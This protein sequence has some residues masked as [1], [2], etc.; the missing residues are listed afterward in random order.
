MNTSPPAFIEKLFPSIRSATDPED[1]RRTTILGWILLTSVIIAPLNAINHLVRGEFKIAGASVA[2]TFLNL[3]VFFALRKGVSSLRLAWILCTCITVIIWGGVFRR[4]SFDGLVPQSLQLIPLISVFILGPRRGWIFGFLSGL[5]LIGLYLKWS[6]PGGATILSSALILMSFIT[7]AV[8]VS[9]TQ[10][11]RARQALE[12]ARREAEENRR[13]AEL[14]QKEAEHAKALAEKSSA[15]K[16]EFLANMSHEIRTPMNAVIGMTG[17]LL[18]TKLDAEQRSFTEIVR[19]SSEALLA[20][21]NDILDFSKIEAGELQIE[22]LPMSIRECVENAVELL[23]AKAAEKHIELAFHIE[24]DVPVAIEGDPT[25]IQ[26][27]LVNLISNAVKFTEQGEVVITVRTVSPRDKQVTISFEVRDTGRG[28]KPEAIPALF[29]PFTQED[30]STTRRYGGTG[31]GLTICKRLVEAMG[32]K[33]EVQSEVGVGTTMRFSLVG[34]IAPYTRPRYMDEVGPLTEKRILVVDD[35]ATN[36]EIVRRYLDS[37]GMNAITVD[38][39]P[40]ALTALREGGRNLDCAI[41]DM[42]MPEMDGLM[43]A[44]AIHKEPGFQNLPLIMLTSLG[45]REQSEEMRH[46]R[47]FLT[48]PLKPSRLFNTLLA[49]FSPEEDSSQTLSRITLVNEIPSGLRVLLADDNIINQKVALMSLQ[50]LGIR[51]DAVA[52]GLEVI[53]AIRNH[54][55]DLILM[56]VQMP[57]LDGLAATRQIRKMNVRQQPYIIAATANATIEDREE[58][59]AA[60]MNAYMSKPYRLRDLHRCMLDYLQ[61]KP[62]SNPGTVPPAPKSS[63]ARIF[64]SSALEQ[65]NVMFNDD[66]AEIDSFFDGSLPDLARQMNDVAEARNVD[67]H[68]LRSAAHSLKG[69]SGALASHELQQCAATLESRARDGE[70]GEAVKSDWEKVQV[71]HDRFVKAVNDRSYR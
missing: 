41:L 55:Y 47:A 14:A 36:R 31:L 19:T 20:I 62:T 34:T 23:A 2:G 43:L 37:W 51:A 8:V 63:H 56:D 61:T 60:G 44:S 40:A 59:L 42:H 45:Q 54:P 39:G 50:K 29:D 57:E 67:A 69:G 11:V 33:F 64:S 18:E 12:K 52:N 16:T 22:R 35:N 9:E 53:E 30:A 15:A 38:S 6:P 21:I 27:V 4:E 25:R 48:K 24:H 66:Q 65:L 1:R 68:G 32:G 13:L 5:F 17:L 3:A 28:I 26:Q 10:R 7:A 70:F 46:F 58:C 49:V 71:A